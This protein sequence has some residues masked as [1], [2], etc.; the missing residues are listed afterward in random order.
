MLAVYLCST[1]SHGN[2]SKSFRDI[3]ITIKKVSKIKPVKLTKREELW[4]TGAR[5][6]DLLGISCGIRH[7]V[8]I[9]ISL[10]SCGLRGGTFFTSVSAFLHEYQGFPANPVMNTIPLACQWF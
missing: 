4:A 5:P 1:V 2:G 10:E 9:S 8:V 3:K 6:C 7:W